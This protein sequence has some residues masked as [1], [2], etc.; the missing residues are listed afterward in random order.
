LRSLRWFALSTLAAC[1]VQP[2]PDAA[3]PSTSAAPVVVPVLDEAT[4]TPTPPTAA[5]TTTA[6]P[7]AA[8]DDIASPPSLAGTRGADP[9]AAARSIDRYLAWL[10]RHPSSGVTAS[11]TVSDVVAPGT[12]LIADWAVAPPDRPLAVE[13]EVRTNTG[14][15]ADLHATDATGR[16]IVTLLWW[17]GRW[18]FAAVVPLLDGEPLVIV[19]A[20]A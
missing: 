15:R 3:A 11:A 5:A 8:D 1:G 10:H 12:A 2:I 4:T 18:R 14:T 19:E 7:A 20:G 13:Y 17:D 16:S 9:I 6:K